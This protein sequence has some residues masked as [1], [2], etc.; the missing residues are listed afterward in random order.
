MPYNFQNTDIE[1]VVDAVNNIV[2]PP[3]PAGLATEATLQNVNTALYNGPKTESV[4]D[5]SKISAD[6]LTRQDN[7]TN[8]TVLAFATVAGANIAAL[9]AALN[10]WIAANPGKRTISFSTTGD[11]VVGF[12]ATILYR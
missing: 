7:D 1:Q 6:N 9:D 8:N 12:A 2:I 3:V 5:A 11:A 4:Y 10:A